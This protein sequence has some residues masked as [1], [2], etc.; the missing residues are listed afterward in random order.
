MSKRLQVVVA[1]SD[2]ERY[3]H[4]ARAAG[5]TL[6]AW[7]RQAMNTAERETSNGDVEAKLAA[8]RRAATYNL[9]VSDIDTMLAENELRYVPNLPGLD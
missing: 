5:L 7:A 1:E 9:P 3:E 8:I 6:S 4:S 2:L